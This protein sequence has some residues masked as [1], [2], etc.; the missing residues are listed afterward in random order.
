MQDTELAER[1]GSA[2]A[3]QPL[4]PID[5]DRLVKRGQRSLR[6]RKILGASAA[7]AGVAAVAASAALL[8]G[9]G[10]PARTPSES[11]PVAGT[12]GSQ[13]QVPKATAEPPGKDYKL[14]I[15]DRDSYQRSPVRDENGQIQRDRNGR[16]VMAIGRATKAAATA[17]VR[18][19]G[20][21]V[22]KVAFDL[23]PGWTWNGNATPGTYKAFDMTGKWASL[24]SLTAT[25]RHDA[26]QQR[27]Q[28]ICGDVFPKPWGNFTQPHDIG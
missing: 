11:A 2:V 1:L 15:V 5:V 27:S 9:F 3:H 21:R 26:R 18:C 22:T 10:T 14:R 25:L 8:P 16:P 17:T 4:D 23:E 12:A 28:F 13:V 7:A 24:N 6:R 20:S 19:D